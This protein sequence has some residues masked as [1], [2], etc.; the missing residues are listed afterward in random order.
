MTKTT[1]AIVT[2]QQVGLF[3]GASVYHIQD[4]HVDQARRETEEAVS[5]IRLRTSL[6][7]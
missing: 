4:N 5:A 2:G 1:F 6:L 3:G 7:G